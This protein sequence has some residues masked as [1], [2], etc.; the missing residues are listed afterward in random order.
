MT[1][2]IKTLPYIQIV[3]AVLITGAILMQKSDNNAGGVFGGQDN[4]NAAYHSRRG[5]E[6]SIFNITIV[7]AVLFAAASL[8]VLVLK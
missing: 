2:F 4:W 3:L 1:T 5:F 6:K 8:L 7:L